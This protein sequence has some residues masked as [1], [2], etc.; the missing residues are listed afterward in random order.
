MHIRFH[1]HMWKR[2][3]NTFIYHIPGT[4]CDLSGKPRVTRVQYVCY[5]HG[6]HEVYS[7]KETSTC[8]YEIVILSPLLCDH[9]AFKPTEVR[10]NAI[11]CLPVGDAPK[12]PRSLLKMEVDNLRS[13]HQSVRLTNNVSMLPYRVLR[14][15][16]NY[17]VVLLLPF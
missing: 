9:P 14:V 1:I 6:K 10:E 5:T 11:D 16:L 17:C 15:I 8:E 7:F 12:K 4:I 3:G 2:F 13:V